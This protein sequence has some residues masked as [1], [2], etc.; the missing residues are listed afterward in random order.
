MEKNNWS[1][2]PRLERDKYYYIMQAFIPEYLTTIIY[3][4]KSYLCTKEQRKLGVSLH[5]QLI[6]N[7]YGRVEKSREYENN[8]EFV[9]YVKSFTDAQI[10]NLALLIRLSQ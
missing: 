2:D 8:P 10:K 4:R 5:Y 7:F 6:E 9:E 3:G 1:S